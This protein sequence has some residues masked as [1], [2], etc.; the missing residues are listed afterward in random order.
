MF[1][2]FNLQQVEAFLHGD[3]TVLVIRILVA[4]DHAEH[5]VHGRTGADAET[6]PVQQVADEHGRE[7][8]ACAV[9]ESGDLVILQVE[10]TVV[11]VVIASHGVLAVDLT[12]G[13]EGRLGAK[14][15]A[16]GNRPRYSWGR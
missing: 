6:F 4:L 10:V 9:E 2:M 14:F 1:S 11:A 12:T 15:A 5:G 13:D 16:S 8:V 3:A 7:D